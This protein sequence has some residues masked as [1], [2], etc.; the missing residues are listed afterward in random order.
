MPN[1]LHLGQLCEYSNVLCRLA[2]CIAPVKFS[3]DIQPSW[4]KNIGEK[5]F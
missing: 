3:P 1:Y 4:K 5:I 2:N